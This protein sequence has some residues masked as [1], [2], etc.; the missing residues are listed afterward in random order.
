MQ[1]RAARGVASVARSPSRAISPAVELAPS[2]PLLTDARGHADRDKDIGDFYTQ[3]GNV[4]G[5]WLSREPDRI[6]LVHACEV[7]RMGQENADLD[8][9]AIGER[10]P[11]LFLNRGAG[12]VSGGRVDADKPET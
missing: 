9:L 1:S 10:L 11:C 2:R 8:R 5:W 7:G 12:E 4:A 3:L 6:F